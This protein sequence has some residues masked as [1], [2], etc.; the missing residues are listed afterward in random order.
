MSIAVI[1]IRLPVV[2]RTPA[3]VGGTVTPAI[4]GGTVTPAIVVRIVAIP[5]TIII[6]VIWSAAIVV[7]S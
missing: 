1:R 7:R 6:S 2:V 4:V 3:I 5:R